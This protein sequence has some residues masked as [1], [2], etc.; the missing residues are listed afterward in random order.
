MNADFKKN[1]KSFVKNNIFVLLPLIILIVLTFYNFAELKK[2]KSFFLNTNEQLKNTLK[3]EAEAGIIN[4][5]FDSINLLKNQIEIKSK[6]NFLIIEKFNSAADES[7]I[8]IESIHTNNDIS[9]E[10]R[11]GFYKLVKFIGLIENFSLAIS[12]NKICQINESG[13]ILFC[14]ITIENQKL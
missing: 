11:G 14:K 12:S 3:S 10:C 2:S 8:T 1:M 6:K 5:N 4:K 7:G 9:I 13:N